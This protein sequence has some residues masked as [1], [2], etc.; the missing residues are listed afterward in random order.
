MDPNH[1][2]L[3]YNTNKYIYDLFLLVEKNL[4]LNNNNNLCYLLKLSVF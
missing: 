4:F 1:I 3:Y 2:I